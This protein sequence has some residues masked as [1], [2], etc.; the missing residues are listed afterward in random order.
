MR[1]HK[2]SDIQMLV[3]LRC[4]FIG[5]WRFFQLLFAQC[6]CAGCYGPEEKTMAEMLHLIHIHLYGG[7]AATDSH[8][9]ILSEK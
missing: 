3:S 6:K 8:S 1:I 4:R 5:G 2:V 9:S 7:N